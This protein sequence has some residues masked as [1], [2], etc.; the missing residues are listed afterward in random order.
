MIRHL[1]L[2]DFTALPWFPKS[3]LMY[4]HPGGLSFSLDRPTVIVGPNGSGKSAL[5][6]VL[7]L[8]FLAYFVGVSAL[9]NQYLSDHWGKGTWWTNQSKWGNDW[10]FLQGLECDTDNSPMLYYRPGHVP[11]NESSSTHSLLMG[12][13]DEARAYQRDTHQRS[14][15]E[16]NRA[17]LEK[18]LA[19]LR[20]T[21][22][23]SLDASHWRYGREA[24]SLTGRDSWVGPND[25]KAEVLK[26][27]FAEPG[28]HPLV[29]LDEPEQ[30][31]DALEELKLWA[32]LEKPSIAQV[33]IATHSLYPLLHPERF[34]FIE[35]VP[36]YMQ[37]VQESL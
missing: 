4:H 3:S 21:T 18:M 19:V 27:L 8:R 11:G 34:S 31:L 9:D 12:Y 6:T 32:E 35:T 2:R 20:G 16:G 29:A 10:K 37:N 5:L 24:R 25:H 22:P 30:S 14:S 23:L 7:A 13:V 33:I 36:D 15:G 1:M 28:Q 17:R 26:K